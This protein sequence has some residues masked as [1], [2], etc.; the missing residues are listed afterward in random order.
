MILMTPP[1]I[2][3]S[4]ITVAITTPSPCR[5][6]GGGHFPRT[7][8]TPNLPRRARH[9]EFCLILPAESLPRSGRWPRITRPS[10]CLDPK[11][12][13]LLDPSFSVTPLLTHQQILRGPPS[14][15][16]PNTDRS[17]APLP[18]P[19]SEQ[20][21]VAHP[22][23]DSGLLPAPLALAPEPLHRICN[24]KTLPSIQTRGTGCPHS[25]PLRG[26]PHSSEN[27]SG[28]IQPQDLGIGRAL[29]LRMSAPQLTWHLPS[30]S[31]SHL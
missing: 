11:R 5:G 28:T 6:R 1:S 29:L 2:P 13:G 16:V 17:P 26:S 21:A 8:R 9:A 12:W 19:R 7:R 23:C 3:S 30:L 18:P 20:A 31:L 24:T 15:R 27:M 14:K 4:H 10:S 25:P 22:H